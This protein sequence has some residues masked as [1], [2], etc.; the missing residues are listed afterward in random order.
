MV[1]LLFLC[2][3]ALNTKYCDG[4]RKSHFIK[5]ESPL[6]LLVNRNSK[7]RKIRPSSEWTINYFGCYL[8]SCTSSWDISNE[9]FGPLLMFHKLFLPPVHCKSCFWNVNLC[10]TSNQSCTNYY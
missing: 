4:E 3:S 8:V 5:N 6:L 1:L 10:F 2:Y 7:T 9:I